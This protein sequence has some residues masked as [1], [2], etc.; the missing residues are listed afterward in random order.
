MNILQHYNHL[1]VYMVVHREGEKKKKKK[2]KK[3]KFK[4]KFQL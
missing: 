1:T 2:K 3:K 4:K